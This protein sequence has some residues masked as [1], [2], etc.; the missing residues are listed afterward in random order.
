MEQPV[1]VPS[2]EHVIALVAYPGFTVL[3]LIGPLDVLSALPAPSRTVVVG[4]TIASLATATHEPAI[5]ASLAAV[6]E[7]PISSAPVPAPGRAA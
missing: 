1:L 4:E 3:D 7:R 6:I 2:S 5:N